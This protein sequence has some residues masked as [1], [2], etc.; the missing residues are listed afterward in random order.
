MIKRQFK[1]SNVISSKGIIKFWK[2]EGQYDFFRPSSTSFQTCLRPLNKQF[3]FEGKIS[4]LIIFLQILNKNM[5]TELD[6]EVQG[7]QR[8][9][10]CETFS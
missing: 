7:H 1:L 10:S 2:L 8:L 6:I 3:K 5:K 9:N 4:M